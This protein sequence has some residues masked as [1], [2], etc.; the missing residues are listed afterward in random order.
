[1]HIS[2]YNFISK[3]EKLA[4]RTW[5]AEENVTIGN[6]IARAS[7]GVTKRAN[8]VFAVGDYPSEQDWLGKIESFY[9]QRRLPSIFHLSGASPSG[10]DGQLA[11]RGYQIEFPCDIMIADT[12]D[13][14]EHTR[15]KWISKGKS[16]IQVKIQPESDESW[17]QEFLRI[18]EFTDDRRNFYEGLFQRIALPKGFV[19]MQQDGETLAIGTAIAENGWAGLLN[20]AVH[21]DRRGQGLSYGLLHAL[22]SWSLEQ[23][24]EQLYLQV[25]QNNEPAVRLYSNL[26]FTPLSGY[27]YRIKYDF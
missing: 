14:W 25:I 17:M 11:E 26:G 24:A 3:I 18:E 16:E 5:P 21:K 19:E 23:K 13:V 20:V 7:R 15:L 9:K 22:A 12:K 2:D 6:W 27:H 1:M 4:Y 8:S 10:L